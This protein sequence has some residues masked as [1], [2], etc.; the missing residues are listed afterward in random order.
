[1]HRIARQLF[2]WLKDHSRRSTS[3]Q[4][5]S[6]LAE[7]ASLHI[8]RYDRLGR[9]IYMSPNLAEA[10]NLSTSQTI[11]KARR[12]RPSPNGRFDAYQEALGRVLATGEPAELE[13][14]VSYTDGHTE[15]HQIRLL[16]ERDSGKRLT[17]VLCIGRDITEKKLAETSLRAQE[18][19]LRALAENSPDNIVRYDRECRITFANRN[20]MQRINVPVAPTV[21]RRS[22]DI[23]WGE[24]LEAEKQ[25]YREALERVINSGEAETVEV[26][27]GAPESTQPRLHHIKMVAERDAD[28]QVK[29]AIV[30]G[31]DIT[32]RK[33][34]EELLAAREREFRSLAENLPDIV[35]RFDREGRRI[36]VNGAYQRFT[37]KNAALLL[38]KTVLET[39]AFSTDPRLCHADILQAIATGKECNVEW[40]A[41]GDDGVRRVFHTRACPEF[42]A[43]GNVVSLLAVSRDVSEIY[44]YRSKIHELAYF[45]ALTGL[46]NRAHFNEC[47]AK[48]LQQARHNGERVGVLMMDLDRFKTINDTLGHIAG[49]RLLCEVAQR[50]LTNVRAVDTVAR[51]GGDEFIVVS[52]NSKS[53]AELLALAKRVLA[54]IAAPVQ[55]DGREFVVQASIGIAIFPDHGDTTEELVRY[56]DGALYRAKDAGRNNAQFYTPDITD[57]AVVRLRLEADLRSAIARGAL[58][59][60]YQPKVEL[61]T[62]RIVGAEALVRWAHPERGWISPSDFIGIAEETGLIVPLAEQVMRKACS[63]ASRWNAQEGPPRNIAVNLSPRQFY[64]SDLPTVVKRILSDTGCKPEWIEFEITEGLLLVNH[65]TTLDTLS[66]LSQMGVRIA[67]DDFGTGYSAMGYLTRLPISTLK[68]D[69]TFTQ[70]ASGSKNNQVLVQA[71]VAMAHG[72]GLDVVAEGV[73]TRQLADWLADIGCHIGQGY[74]WSPAIPA[75]A[76]LD[77]GTPAQYPLDCH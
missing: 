7:K 60:H 59:V 16:A 61:A 75:H 64:L 43:D 58:D 72:L 73:E 39:S 41:T 33:Q 8:S 46:A 34:M 47:I 54:A 30:F 70:P 35:M 10:L 53:D 56:A 31:R 57:R 76:L 12:D 63:V 40:Q 71:I 42:D 29:G 67:I 65:S 6:Y 48:T 51:L 18:Q 1:M 11:G 49:D 44:R 37:G 4:I 36:Y 23:S 3:E 28:Q 27:V 69:R 14:S 17:G 66:A 19:E 77:K 50:L 68:I 21:G 13:L 55:L 74:L 20:L 2:S 22:Q 45:D 52:P 25:R 24:T 15:I 38:G 5:L 62:G 26:L 32:E 9:Q